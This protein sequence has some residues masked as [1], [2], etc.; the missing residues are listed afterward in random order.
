VLN[1]PRATIAAG[2]PSYR[3]CFVEGADL[4]LGEP[5]LGWVK[6]CYCGLSRNRLAGFRGMGEEVIVSAWVVRGVVGDME[7]FAT[8]IVLQPE[9]RQRTFRV[10]DPGGISYRC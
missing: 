2:R 1:G 4:F 7:D 5:D 8:V 6:L 9:P 3:A 10:R